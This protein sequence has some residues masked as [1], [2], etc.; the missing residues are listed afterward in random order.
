MKLNY[1]G[2][3]LFICLIFLSGNAASQVVSKKIPYHV[4][5]RSEPKGSG[6]NTLIPEKVGDFIR[7]EYQDPK[8]GQDGEAL[9]KSKDGEVFMLFSRQDNPD[10]VKEVMKVIMD[11]VHMHIAHAISQINLETDPAYIHLIGPKIAFFAWNRGL[12]C[13]SADSTSGNESVLNKF[14]DS[15]PY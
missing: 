15:F 10:D 2:S 14:M 11:E 9:Y 3:V 6:F 7:M 12:Y 5:Q 4:D 8:P 1:L 13:F